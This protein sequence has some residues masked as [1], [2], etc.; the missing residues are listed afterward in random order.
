MRASILATIL[1]LTGLSAVQAGEISVPLGYAAIVNLPPG[2]VRVEVDNTE[3][4]DAIALRNPQYILKANGE[5]VATITA[6]G[7]NDEVVSTSVVRVEP[8]AFPTPDRVRFD[9]DGDADTT[10]ELA[11]P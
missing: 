4:A 9:A 5:G 6:Y 11:T 2:A 3:I 10:R 8:D 1:G 7:E